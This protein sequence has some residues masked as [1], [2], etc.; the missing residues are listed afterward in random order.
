MKTKPVFLSLA[1]LLTT[2]GSIASEVSSKANDEP[3]T[4]IIIRPSH[5]GGTVYADWQLDYIIGDVQY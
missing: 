3:T 5:P 4:P 2:L 1:L